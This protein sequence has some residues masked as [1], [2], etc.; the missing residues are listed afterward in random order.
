MLPVGPA[1]T[2]DPD[3]VQ[4]L[5]SQLEEAQKRIEDSVTRAEMQAQITDATAAARLVIS[6]LEE[7][8]KSLEDGRD[9][10]IVVKDQLHA[11]LQKLL[12]NQRLLRSVRDQAIVDERRLHSEEQKRMTE[13]HQAELERLKKVHEREMNEVCQQAVDAQNARD[14]AKERLEEDLAELRRMMV[15]HDA[16]IVECAGRLHTTVRG[17]CPCHFFFVR[18]A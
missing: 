17:E 12:E 6:R 16:V 11:D 14:T 8:V 7:K 5:R 3:T 10:L 18:L 13:E 2:S 1:G 15:D 4:A 9:A